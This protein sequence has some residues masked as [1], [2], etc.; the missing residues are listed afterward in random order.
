MDRGNERVSGNLTTIAWCSPR[1]L[2]WLE[3]KDIIGNSYNLGNQSRY[4]WSAR[5]LDLGV[6][7]VSLSPRVMGVTHISIENLYQ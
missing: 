3:Q 6:W 5:T 1:R 7:A 2:N 4:V